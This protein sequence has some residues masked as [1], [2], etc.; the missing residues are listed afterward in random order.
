MNILVHENQLSQNSTREDKL[1][2]TANYALGQK[3]PI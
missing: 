3:V 2:F 1:Y